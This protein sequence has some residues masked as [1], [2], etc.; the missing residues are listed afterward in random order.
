MN[1]LIKDVK[2]V[3]FAASNSE[4]FR[5]LQRLKSWC[6]EDCPSTIWTF[7]WGATDAEA[8]HCTVAECILAF[9]RNVMQDFDSSIRVPESDSAI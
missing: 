3:V 9:I 8:V 1:L 6:L 4:D 5:V 7:V 2:V